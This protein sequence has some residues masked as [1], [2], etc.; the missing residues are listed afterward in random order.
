VTNQLDLFEV[1]PDGAPLWRASVVGHESAINKLRELSAQT[2]NEV[3][4]IDL[5]TNTTIAALN[6][7]ES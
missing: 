2:T 6:T 5:R 7:T 1:L 4:V 3:R